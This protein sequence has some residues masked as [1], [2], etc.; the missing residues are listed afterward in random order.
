MISATATAQDS[1]YSVET[2]PTSDEL[3]IY[4]ASLIPGCWLVQGS[5]EQASQFWFEGYQHFWNIIDY[6]ELHDAFFE[7]NGSIPEEFQSREGFFDYA[8]AVLNEGFA[9]RSGLA[10]EYNQ[11]CREL[12]QTFFGR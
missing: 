11:K 5:S 7:Y 4:A 9:A 1:S 10:L 3:T 6:R 2:D 12:I 8:I